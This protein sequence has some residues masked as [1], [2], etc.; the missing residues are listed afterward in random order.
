MIAGH[1]SAALHRYVASTRD[2]PSGR[3]L[4]AFGVMTKVT[5]LLT[6]ATHTAKVQTRSTLEK[7]MSKR[8]LC[9]ISVAV[10]LI[11]SLTSIDCAASDWVLRHGR[12]NSIFWVQPI[13]GSPVV[14][15][16]VLGTFP[17]RKAACEEA[18]N[19]YEAATEAS[20][21]CGDFQANT[22]AECTKDNVDLPG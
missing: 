11:S 22:R 17:T 4:V 6:W 15:P 12:T 10:F 3:G 9:Q 20:D 5:P 18:V 13:T 16:E 7:L 1:R 14:A 2:V 21:K 8:H 19:R